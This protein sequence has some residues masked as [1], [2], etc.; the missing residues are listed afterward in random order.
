[1]EEIC[2][3]QKSLDNKILVSTTKNAIIFSYSYLQRITA[4][5]PNGHCSNSNSHNVIGMEKMH[6]NRSDAA[7]ATTK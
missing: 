1:M 4:S 6:K 2:Q 3:I 7:K 5:I